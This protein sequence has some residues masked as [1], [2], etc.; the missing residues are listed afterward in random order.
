MTPDDSARIIYDSKTSVIRSAGYYI[1]EIGRSPYKIYPLSGFK[2]C[3]KPVA[4]IFKHGKVR[5][6][7][8]KVSDGENADYMDH[9]ERCFRNIEIALEIIGDKESAKEESVYTAISIRRAKAGK[10]WIRRGK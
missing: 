10:K 9:I 2:Y 3:D 4:E 8:P 1:E 7:K 6:F 5:K